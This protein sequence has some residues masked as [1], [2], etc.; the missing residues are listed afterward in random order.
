[1]PQPDLAH[2]KKCAS[3]APA[4]QLVMYE[5]CLAVKDRACK[6]GGILPRTQAEAPPEVAA[7][8]AQAYLLTFCLTFS[9]LYSPLH[10]GILLTFYSQRR[11]IIPD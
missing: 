3:V 7:I 5:G 11:F 8:T 2:Q 4:E 9:H 6:V 10:L 1:M